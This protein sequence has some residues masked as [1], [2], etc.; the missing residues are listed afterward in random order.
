MPKGFQINVERGFD[1]LAREVP[2][3]SLLAVLNGLD[4]RLEQLLTSDKAQT[5]KITAN[6]PK[7][8]SVSKVATSQPI[9]AAAHR[10]LTIHRKPSFSKI[11]KA[12]ARAKR[13]TDTRQL[14]ARMSKLPM[15]SKSSDGTIYHIPIQVPK[16]SQL[17]PSLR[18]VKEVALFVPE[19]YN[20]EPCT[21]HLKGVEGQE[22]EA[23]E[24]AFAE[25]AS[26]EKTSTLMAHVNYLAQNMKTMTAVQI[27]SSLPQSEPSQTTQ[28]VPVETEEQPVKDGRSDPDR[29]H[30]RV[31]ARPPEW[32]NQGGESDSS[33]D[34]T[35]SDEDGSDSD[36]EELGDGG[37]QIQRSA[38]M[39]STDHGI[40]MSF[41]D[42]ELYGIELLEVASLALTLK[43]DR[44]KTLADISNLRP[45]SVENTVTVS[46]SCSKC[47]YTMTASYRPE[48][49]HAN[50][51]RAGYLDLTDCTVQDMLPSAFMP[52]CSECSTRV[53]TPS[54]VV[55]VRGDTTLSICREC[56]QKMTFKI[57]SIRFLRTSSQQQHRNQ[58]PRKGPRENLG[59]TSGAP[60][61]DNGRCSHYR[62]SYRWFRFSCCNKVYPCDRCHDEK[63]EPKHSNEHANR[64]ICGWC[65][66]EQNYRPED[67]G[68]CGR[69]MVAKKGGGFWE[70]GKG[71]RDPMRMSRK[72]PRKY[73]R[74]G[75]K[76]KA[77]ENR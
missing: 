53:G 14:E 45:S 29:P 39:A 55:A 32:D 16:A 37:A 3:K 26:Q 8:D 64:M 41:P 23:V 33:S 60:L 51:V 52:T 11:Q 66:R 2:R 4:R 22:A 50:N 7:P 21:V 19:L 13:E 56:H 71:T 65:S 59:I 18:A 36:V 48:L 74:V 58:A 77:K 20:L 10:P 25:Y 28:P 5:L 67:C 75:S 46:Q 72:E 35:E 1:D 62:K 17:P 15:Y 73:K 42:I 70:G 57:P 63:A 54:A 61:P 40:A 27:K 24:A 44:C 49:V 12:E 6:A 69:S 30:L 76:N 38:A 31:I 43:C 9:A 47:A 68:V 34:Y